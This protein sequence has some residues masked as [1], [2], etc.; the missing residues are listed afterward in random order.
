MRCDVDDVD[1]VDDVKS[2][3]TASVKV[4][5]EMSGMQSIG[6]MII[7]QDLQVEVYPTLYSHHTDRALA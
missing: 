2:L 6:M 5:N 4:L 3:L 1:D 7:P